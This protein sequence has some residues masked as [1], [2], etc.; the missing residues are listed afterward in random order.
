MWSGLMSPGSHQMFDLGNRHP[1]GG[2]H[3]RI[4]VSRGLPVDE[5]AFGVAHPGVHDG[6]VGDD[7]A[8]HDVL[9]AVELALFLALGDV[10]AGAGAGEEGRD[11]RAAGADAFGERALRIE[12]DLEFAR[13]ILLGEQLVLAHVGRDHLLDLLGLQQQA[14]PRAVDACIVGDDGEVLHPG[15]ADRRNQHLGDAA[16]AEAAGTDQHAV[17]EHARERRLGVGIDLLHER[18]PSHPRCRIVQFLYP[19]P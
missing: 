11:A 2:C 15:I 1:A 16:K 6:E 4:E 18:K 17:L 13:E 7:A 14:E 19:G 9:L 3:H 10:G 8:L 12:F 5:I